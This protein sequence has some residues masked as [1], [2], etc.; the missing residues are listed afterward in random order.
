MTLKTR[1]TEDRVWLKYSS[2]YI[3]LCWVDENPN[4]LVS[5]F[6][7]FVGG[8]SALGAQVFGSQPKFHDV[9]VLHK[10]G[11]IMGCFP[12]FHEVADID[13]LSEKI[14]LRLGSQ[15][16]RIVLWMSI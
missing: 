9:L 13:T 4:I 3:C 5:N 15:Y 8:G 16:R 14:Y 12:H 10:V 11:E 1:H 2:S 6:T 7:F